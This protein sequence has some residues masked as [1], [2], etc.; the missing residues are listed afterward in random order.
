M[1][2]R[3]KHAPEF[4]G[5]VA[6]AAIKGQKTMTELCQEYSLHANVIQKWKHLAVQNIGIVFGGGSGKVSNEEDLL[7]LHAK[8][9]ELVIERDFL[10][11][12]LK[13]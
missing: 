11:K 10:K 12:V 1:T 5:K 13:M 2:K 9:G 7:K 8:I 4:K 3:T 6:L